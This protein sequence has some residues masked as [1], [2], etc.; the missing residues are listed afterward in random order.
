MRSPSGFSLVEVLVALSLLSMMLIGATPLFVFV[1]R[2]NSAAEDQ[3]FSSALASE[4]AEEMKRMPLASVASGADVVYRDNIAYDRVWVVANDTPHPTMRT[5]TVTVTARRV[6][7]QGGKRAG[8]N[9][10]YRVP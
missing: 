9:R 1:T 3:T 7:R 8:T 2:A 4:K 10:F 6:N 5:V